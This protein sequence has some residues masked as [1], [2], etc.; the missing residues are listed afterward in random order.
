MTTIITK[1]GSGAPAAGQLS[2][3]E[4]AVDLTNKELYTKDS[5]G[6]VIKVGGTGGGETGTF[7]DLTATS[8]FTSPGIDDNATSTA[9][10]IDAS[11]DFKVGSGSKT[12]TV[13][14]GAYELDIAGGLNLSSGRDNGASMTFEVSN[15]EK[16][17]IDAGGNVGI[18][19]D[20]TNNRK[21]S[22]TGTGDL[23]ELRSTNSGSSGAQLD[24]I[25]DSPSPADGDSVG[26]LNF[27]NDNV[28]LANVTGK[29]ASVGSKLGELHFGTRNSGTYNSSAM[30]LASN[31]NVGIGVTAP[32]SKM[33]VRDSLRV[34]TSSTG[35][36][37]SDGVLMSVGA[38]GEAYLYN[39]EAQPWHFGTSGTTRM[40]I[41]SSGNVGI[42]TSDPGAG[43]RLAVEGG[44]L[45]TRGS[46]TGDAGVK[47]AGVG[48]SYAEIDA[49][50]NKVGWFMPL[51]LQR[52]GG[53]VGIGTDSPIS[54]G[55][56]TQGITIKGSAGGFTNYQYN[57][58]NTGY[59]VAAS[60]ALSINTFT[61]KN[62]VLGTEAVERMRLDSSGNLLVGKTTDPTVGTGHYIKPNGETYHTITTG[63][64][65]LHVYSTSASA[66][67]FYVGND[68]TVHAT[69]TS[70]SAIS[71]ASLKENIRDLDK[72]LDTINSLQPRRFDWKNGDGND[73]MGFIAQEVE[74]VMP[75]L[76]D[77][78]Q[79]NKDETKKSLRTGDMIPSMVKAIQ[80]LSTQ[81]SELK[82]EVA[83]L[84]GA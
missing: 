34:T 10:T 78:A 61:G 1:N 17:R 68:G 67:R 5:G 24:L 40:T 43:V 64:N 81:V 2:Q 26:M 42:G 35:D 19:T 13:G 53:N 48:T 4:L 80:E 56:G 84:K 79:Y 27:A 38:S 11:G 25:H 32:A 50:A 47:L 29:V 55:A 69:N 16:M 60:D 75:E 15:T 30:V 71:D 66:F 73:I 83:A 41:D 7:T 58:A 54:L 6:N 31:G 39:Y 59:L 20:N 18:G 65:T 9:I 8:S 74:E 22:V 52:Q 76:I 21:L 82:A 14:S 37:A 72:G 57:A 62:L 45:I 77:E 33:H 63:L 51:V 12:Y 70:I 49:F 23:M 44:E 28:Q 3:G 36:T 46:A